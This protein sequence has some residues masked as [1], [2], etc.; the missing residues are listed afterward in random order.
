MKK[1]YFSKNMYIEVWEWEGGYRRLEVQKG[2]SKE[3]D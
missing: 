3:T 1:N 2:F